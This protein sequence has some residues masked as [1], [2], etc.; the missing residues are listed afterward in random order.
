VKAAAV[1]DYR[2]I[3]YRRIP[4]FLFEYLDGGSYS[5]ATL[6]RNVSDLEATSLR[7]RVLRDVSNVSLSAN[8][9]GSK[10]SLPIALAPIGLAG[11]NARRGEVHAALAA[12]KAGV[13]FLSVHRIGLCAF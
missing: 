3:A 9:V 10:V 8:F 12:E 11:L 5:E 2:E 1:T 7:Q 4:R 6:R 13:P